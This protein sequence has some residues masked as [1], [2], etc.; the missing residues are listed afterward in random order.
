[1]IENLKELSKLISLCRK[2]GVISLKYQ[3]VE[4]QLG[5]L[6]HKPSRSEPITMDPGKIPKPVFPVSENLIPDN[7][8][9]DELTHDQLLFY[10]AGNNQ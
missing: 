8:Q 5:P 7:P 1:M 3:G 4:L 10:S 2:S 9:T 6:P